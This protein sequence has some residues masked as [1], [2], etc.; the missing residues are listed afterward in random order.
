MGHLPPPSAA[1]R[2]SAS[3]P[4]RGNLEQIFM[5]RKLRSAGPASAR[6]DAHVQS[7]HPMDRAIVLLSGGVDSPSAV[8][9]ET[10]IL[11]HRR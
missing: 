8:V 4:F 10:A 5:G 11:G 3:A 7:G 2:M 9:G 1:C 6:G